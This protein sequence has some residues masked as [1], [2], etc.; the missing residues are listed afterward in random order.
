LELWDEQARVRVAAPEFAPVLTGE[1]R[2]PFFPDP[3]GLF[4]DYP[5]ATVAAETIVRGSSGASPARIRQIVA[6]PGAVGRGSLLPSLAELDA[7]LS[8]SMKD[9]ISV[10]ELAISCTKGHFGKA[11]S[12]V[13]WL[14]KHGLVSLE[15]AEEPW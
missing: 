8:R 15:M 6:I 1:P 3:F 13:C 5:S 11:V 12:G 9:P 7:M 2:S 10:G 4:A 14:A